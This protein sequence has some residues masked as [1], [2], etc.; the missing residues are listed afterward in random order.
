MAQPQHC[1]SS[2]TERDITIVGVA[3]G[4]PRLGLCA[5]PGTGMVLREPA[6]EPMG[7]RSSP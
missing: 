1:L 2:A 6:H 5:H 3:V 7:K 4:V